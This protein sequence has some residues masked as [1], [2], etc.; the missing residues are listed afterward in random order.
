[1]NRGHLRKLDF[2]GRIWKSSDG[3]RRTG[4]PSFFQQIPLLSGL[5]LPLIVLFGGISHVKWIRFPQ[6]VLCQLFRIRSI[7]SNLH[8]SCKWGLVL[9]LDHKS[10]LTCWSNWR[11]SAEVGALVINDTHEQWTD[12]G[13]DR[14]TPSCCFFCLILL[15]ICQ[16]I[17]A[18]ILLTNGFWVP[19]MS[20]TP[21]KVPQTARSNQTH[22]WP[23]G[24]I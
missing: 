4:L 13:L 19:T 23:S 12:G 22:S 18:F 5:V 1:M 7:I 14:M 8:H 21:Y 10:S 24:G 11:N 2:T 16:V 20:W 3:K 9:K 6:F 17:C 15:F